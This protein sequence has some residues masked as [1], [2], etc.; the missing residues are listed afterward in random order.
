MI[1]Y[2]D[3][4]PLLYYICLTLHAVFNS[5]QSHRSIASVSSTSQDV[6]VTLKVHTCS[7][8]TNNIKTKVTEENRLGCFD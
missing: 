1:V 8:Q 6:R 3:S 5:E 2:S 7:F 4:R